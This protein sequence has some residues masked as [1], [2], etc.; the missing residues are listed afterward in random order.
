LEKLIYNRLIL[1]LN[2][3]NILTEGQNGFR[4]KK[5]TDTA[6]QSFIER[7]QEA[8]DNGLQATGIFFYL[9]KAYDIL[10]H[11]ILLDKLN[12]YGVRGNINLWF[13]SYLTNH[14]QF[15]EIN[16]SNHISS[17]QFKY[18]G[19]S[20]FKVLKHEVS[21]GSVLGP[22][23]FL[24]YKDDPPLNVKEGDVVLFANDINLLIIERDEHV[25]QHKVNEVMKKLE[26][27]FQEN[28]LMINVGKTVA[29]SFHMRPNRS[30]VKPR[31]TF[32]NMDIAYKL[33]LK[34]L[35]IHITENLRWNTHVHTLSL[36]LSWVSYLI[37]SLKEI[38]GPSVI[39]IIHYSKF[40]A[41]L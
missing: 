21:Q 16:Q 1:F 8:L 26:Y 34:Y 36:K 25:L 9:T 33:E 23:L 35:G 2:K 37:K 24:M 19:S 6:F 5:C 22:L 14:K 38:V 3:H 30:L 27:F 40:Q 17:K 12:S 11:D 10:N 18:T 39:R 29:M 15:V 28:D 13:K 7:I 32:R 4:E 20:S 41:L 31:I